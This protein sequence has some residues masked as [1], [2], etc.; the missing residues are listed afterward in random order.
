MG[1]IN[2]IKRSEDDLVRPKHKNY[3]GYEIDV[4]L[5]D[6]RK[7]TEKVKLLP[8]EKRALAHELSGRE[9]VDNIIILT[10]L[11]KSLGRLTTSQIKEILDDMGF[12]VD[13]ILS[14]AHFSDF[15]AVMNIGGF[16]IPGWVY[17]ARSIAK[18]FPSTEK[19]LLLKLSP[20]KDRLHIR[21]F[22]MNDGSWMIIAH[23]D[24]NWMSLNLPKVYRAHINSGKSVGSGDFVTGTL[25]MYALL[26]NFVNIAKENKVLP[27]K[28]IEE[29][30]KWAYNKSLTEKLSKIVRI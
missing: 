17:L 24:H 26:K 10:N 27:Y 13:T 6:H 14:G 5:V 7:I 20:G 30:T 15:S 22:E 2:T 11:K 4:Q 21:V 23:T 16:A 18:F 8:T 25:M 19:L 9:P 28:D 12:N 3:W 29:I 1:I